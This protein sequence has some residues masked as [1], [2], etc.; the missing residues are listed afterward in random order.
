MAFACSSRSA[1]T[2]QWKLSGSRRPLLLSSSRSSTCRM[3]RKLEGTRPDA[4]PECTPSV[5]ISH[6]QHAA[7]HAA[8]RRGEPQLVV[9]AGAG[10][11]ADHQADVAQ[12]R[13]QRIDVRQ[14]VVGA[15]FLA[16]L[17][18]ARRCAD[19]ARFCA[20]ERLHRG[21]AGVDG[22]AVVG[23]AAAVKL[24]VL[25]LRRPRARGRERQPLNSGCL[26]RWPY[27]STVCFASARGRGDLEEQHRRAAGQAHDLELEAL[28]LLRLD[29]CAP[30]CASRLDVAVLLPSPCRSPATWRGSRCTR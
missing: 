25:V 3:M 20:F 19:A 24:A 21:D 29:P 5:R 26:S 15:R 10:V 7:G 4:S 18:H 6:L 23:A 30:R 11:E 16:G 14:Q 17:D 9:V 12:A 2:S 8:Q 13:A 22:I 28:D 27:I 1:G